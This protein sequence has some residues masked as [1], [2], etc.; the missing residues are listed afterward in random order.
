MTNGR[1][2]TGE[3]AVQEESTCF[4][5]LAWSARRDILWSSR[6]LEQRGHEWR[7][8]RSGGRARA[9]ATRKMLESL[10]GAAAPPFLA[11]R[12]EAATTCG[13]PSLWSSRSRL[14]RRSP[15]R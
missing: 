14:T 7:R 2:R 10:V 13:C 1:R 9:R 15:G 5:P 4:S 12:A 11:C 8:W 3:H 6:H